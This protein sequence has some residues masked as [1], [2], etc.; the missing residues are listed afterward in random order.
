MRNL[1][2]I[3]AKFHSLI[4]FMFYFVFFATGFILGRSGS[5]QSLKELI[6]NFFSK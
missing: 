5:F 3:K 1:L 4:N 6:I 2:H